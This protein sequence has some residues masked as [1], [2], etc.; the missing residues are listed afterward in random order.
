MGSIPSTHGIG[1][2]AYKYELNGISL[3]GINTT[4][5]MADN[6][7]IVNDGKDIDKYSMGWR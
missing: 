3:I 2:L 6:S 7:S 5:D 4:H 1:D